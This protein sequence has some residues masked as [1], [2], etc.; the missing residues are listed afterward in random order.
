MTACYSTPTDDSYGS[1]KLA[2]YNAWLLNPKRRTED[3]PYKGF[4]EDLKLEKAR[5]ALKAEYVA[6]VEAK[7]KAVAAKPV[8][9]KR[10]KKVAGGPSK[11]ERALEI[12]KANQKLAKVNLID[13]IKDEL[14]M[15]LAGATTYYYNAKK[16]A[17]H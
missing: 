10:A 13:K 5:K 6:K 11:L 12:Y 16:M 17:G 14:A 4:P 2:H 15:S 9:A 8:K 3:G 7:E 1:R